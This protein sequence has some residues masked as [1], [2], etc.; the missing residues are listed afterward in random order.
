MSVQC[1]II[2]VFDSI[3]RYREDHRAAANHLNVDPSSERTNAGARA[4]ADTTYDEYVE[5][6]L[7]TMTCG[8][9]KQNG[10]GQTTRPA[11]TND[12]EDTV[13]VV[14]SDDD[15]EPIP[16][17]KVRDSKKR[18]KN[19]PARNKKK[20]NGKATVIV[21]DFKVKCITC[22]ELFENNDALI[23]HKSTYHAR[24]IKRI[25]HCYF[26]KKSMQKKQKLKNHVNAVHTGYI[27]FKCSIGTCSRIFA[28][29]DSLKRHINAAHKGKPN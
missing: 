26:C 28:Y 21:E 1:E 27:R 13:V 12:I 16:R 4:S 11:E 23:Y 17:L 6:E 25:F 5:M 2:S 10:N 18:K 7:S 24:G 3:S 9:I 19:I 8:A 29:K 22:R 20:S 15:E 14:S